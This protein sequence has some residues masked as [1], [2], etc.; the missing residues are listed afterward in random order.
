MKQIIIQIS[1]VIFF[2]GAALSMPFSIIIAQTD[3]FFQENLVPTDQA[4]DVERLQEI[5][6]SEGLFCE[7]C[8]VTGYFGYWTQVGLINL[9]ERYELSITGIVDKE[10]RAKLNEIIGPVEPEQAPL[11]LPE[12][13]ISPEVIDHPINQEQSIASSLIIQELELQI[14]QLQMQIAEFREQLAVFLAENSI[15]TAEQSLPIKENL[16]PTDQ[17]EDVSRL[18]EIL[19]S[20]GLYCQE[21]KV[22]GY[23]GYWTQAGLINLQERYELSITGIVD[24]ETRAKLNELYVSS[25]SSFFEGSLAQEESLST[26]EEI[27]ESISE[28]G[29]SVLPD[30]GDI[31]GPVIVLVGEASVT[32]KQNATYTDAGA[33]ATD[34]VDGDITQK[35]VTDNPVNT[36]ILGTYK[37]TYN[38]SNG[39]GDVAN[40]TR[41]VEVVAQTVV[42][43]GGGGDDASTSSLPLSVTDTTAPSAIMD[44]VASNITSSSI[45]LSWTASGDDGNSGRAFNSAI[46]YSQLPLTRE[47]F[48]SAILV[49]NTPT[50]ESPGTSQSMTVSRFSAGTTYYFAI[51][52]LDEVLNR[53]LLSNVVSVTTLSASDTI[54]PSAITD[55]VASNITSSSIDLSWTASGD[56]GNTGTATSYDIIYSTSI[57][58]IENWRLAI[59]ITGEPTPQAA[60]TTQSMTVSSLSSNTTYYFVIRTN[61]TSP[62]WSD[63]SNIV[64]LV[65]NVSSPDT[66]PPSA[67]T[68]PDTTLPSAITNLS[69]FNPT[70]FSIDLSW[71]ASGDDGNMGTATSYDV[72]YSTSPFLSNDW[73]TSATQ[74]TGEPTPQVAGTTETFTVSGLSGDS[75]YYFVVMTA[76]EEPN[77]SFNS[78]IVD[79]RTGPIDTAA[80]GDIGS[81]AVSNPTIS[82]IDLSW[83]A[84]GDN[85]DTGTAASYDVRYSTSIIS[86]D[87]W[88]S[89]TQA[90]GEPTPQVAG[91]VELMTISDLSQGTIYYFGIKT[92]DGVGN[93]SG[94]SYVVTGTT[95]SC[96]SVALGKQI[97][98]VSTQNQPQI[99]QIDVDPLDV[100]V[101]ELQTITVK[102]RDTNNNPISLS[103]EVNMDNGANPLSF[104]LTA[105]TDLN[106]TWTAFWIST[107]TRCDTYSIGIIAQSASGTSPS[108][109]SL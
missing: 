91:S 53:S 75:L 56:D 85:G 80:P 22:T 33:T 69:A 28:E 6:E 14:I 34:D 29:D 71:T 83:T 86:D 65:I 31:K 104:S 57:I 7:G 106:G 42:V 60:G 45:D 2:A 24:K 58:T 102:V 55:F 64:N 23:F 49:E 36:T 18:Q 37:V 59:Q 50:P 43:S 87:N 48:S 73:L 92:M 109:L 9:Q 99:M 3:S 54:A 90:M 1:V 98:F 101:G 66:T 63:L 105:D 8:N 17:S 20:E 77:L 19:E 39:A 46:R 47:N 16:V 74:A 100:E 96:I 68:N 95:N 27:E 38:V 107:S 44:F 41:T 35:I 62:N 15:A 93:E 26:E 61:D 70:S 97:Y 10:T 108:V 79:L 13:S 88:A 52:V 78:N 21:C 82:S 67:I 72:R 94:L 5:L 4:E 30:S 25:D 40:I 76:D 11:S 81:L 51:K 12:S 84:P 89:G 32:V 103:G